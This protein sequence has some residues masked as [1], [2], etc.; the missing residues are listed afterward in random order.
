MSLFRNKS[1]DVH[2]SAIAGYWYPADPESLRKEIQSHLDN[3][4]DPVVLEMLPAAFISPH[5]GYSWSGDCAAH[6]YRS[7]QG[8]AGRR[9]KRVILMAPSHYAH[10]GGVSTLDLRAY[11]TPLGKVQVDQDVVK[12]LLEKP[13]FGTNPGAHAEEHSDEIQLPFLQV[14][15]QGDWKLVDLVFQGTAPEQWKSI[16]DSILPFVDENTLLVASSDFT[17]F[18][19]RF[20]YMP[21][22]DD[23]PENLRELDLGAVEAALSLDIDQWEGYKSRTGITACGFEPIGTLLALL[24]RVSEAGPD[25]RGRLVNYY[26][27]GDINDDFSSS[28]SYAA[29]LFEPAHVE[30]EALQVEGEELNGEEREYL[31]ALARRALTQF[32]QD[33]SM[34]EPEIP[35]QL[36]EE[37]LMKKRGVF[38]TL[39]AGKR[40]RGC[41]GS[42]PAQDPLARAVM[43]HAVQAAVEDV[44]FT[45]VQLEELNDIHIEISVLTTPREVGSHDEIV[46]G[47]DG[48]LL[49]REPWRSVFLPQVAPEQGWDVPTTLNHLSLKAGLPPEAWKDDETKLHIFQA[50]VFEER[51]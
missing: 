24:R 12:Q 51:E 30:A 48:I 36:S 5:A 37:R 3:V 22:S 19:E 4:K 27:S 43:R 1:H 9:V 10:I 18:G 47:R 31:L 15:L 2:H 39:T 35:S 42:I 20:G 26:R 23:I 14:A 11:E 7:L 49:D 40:L 34:P 38:V 44:R 17:H 29:I 50:Q 21:F 6:L 33:G 32:L 45:P 8:E 46:L 41:I 28:V 13:D 16:A 25:I